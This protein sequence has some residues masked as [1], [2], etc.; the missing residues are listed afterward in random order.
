MCLK[1]NIFILFQ[2]ELEGG[3]EA[4]TAFFTRYPYC[5]GY[6]KKFADL[7]KRKGTKET[8]LQVNILPIASLFEASSNS[9]FMWSVFKG[10]NMK[11]FFYGAR[12]IMNKLFHIAS[13]GV[14]LCNYLRYLKHMCICFQILETIYCIILIHLINMELA[15]WWFHLFCL[16][17]VPSY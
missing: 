15:S 17:K 7:E 10:F 6:W 8:T 3:R 5:Y 14:K 9:F 13:N 12:W 2:S 4:Y 1:I 11:A 16:T